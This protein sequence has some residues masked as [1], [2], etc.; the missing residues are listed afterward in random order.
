MQFVSRDALVAAMN[1]WILDKEKPL[2]QILL[3]Q[4]ALTAPQLQA[5]DAALGAVGAQG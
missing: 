5:L 4:G 2:G 3:D 1:A